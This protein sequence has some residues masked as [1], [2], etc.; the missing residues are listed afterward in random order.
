MDQTQLQQK[1]AEYFAK[2]PPNAQAMFQ[3]MGWLDALEII[4]QKYSLTQTQ[5]ESL[6]TETT[7]LLLGI[8]HPDEYTK[9]LINGLS[10]PK[11]ISEKIM[12]DVNTNILNEFKDELENTY[13]KNAEEL[14]EKEYGGKITLDE[15]FKSLPE[16]VQD[17]ILNSNYQIKLAEIATRNNLS[18]AQMAILEKTT[19]KVLLAIIH[20]NEF[21]KA[22]STE[23]NL[24]QDK[25]NTL[26]D[27][28]NEEVIKSIRA[29]L[30]GH[31]EEKKDTLSEE[32]PV[33]L[34][35]P[36]SFKP[37]PKVEQINTT[38]TSP[39]IGNYQTPIANDPPVP[40]VATTPEK[41]FAESNI[42]ILPQNPMMGA[43]SMIGQR[44]STPFAQAPTISTN[45]PAQSSSPTATLE[46]KED[47]AKKTQDPKRDPYHEAIT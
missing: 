22:L 1:I 44:L 11:G 27:S 5:K 29:I 16:E 46:F 12:I 42:E 8:I 31:A 7:L 20:P 30:L 36:S 39:L 38:P 35:P 43:N 34:P 40:K 45:T 4:S 3:S 41:V 32:P 25:I 28:V 33:P 37:A 2:L 10:I 24:P 21:N 23:L 26:I 13:N 19:N 47:P 17:A 14:A 6:G 9:F 15:R 18:I